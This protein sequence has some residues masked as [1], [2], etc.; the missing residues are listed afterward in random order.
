MHLDGYVDARSLTG[1]TGQSWKDTGAVIASSYCAFNPVDIRF[2]YLR[3]LDGVALQREQCSD[4]RTGLGP[5]S[6]AWN[7]EATDLSEL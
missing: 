5:P 1:E 2:A 6:F 3:V 7:K 4:P